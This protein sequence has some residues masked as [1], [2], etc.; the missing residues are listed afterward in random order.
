[1][2]KARWEHYSHPADVGIRGFGPTKEQ[3]FAQAGLA[4]TAV[5]TDLKTV[6]PKQP[7]K[8][9]CREQDDELLFVDWLNALIYEMA[10]RRM[11]FSK[12][13]V[14]IKDKELRAKAWGEKIDL[15]KHNPV[16]EVKAATY[17]DLKV[18]Q[19]KDGSWLAQCIVDV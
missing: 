12:F 6:E 1:M 14:G 13:E 2:S 8:I 9:T 7:V 17:A 19:S 4:L 18:L 15:K 11:L 10:T 5:I 16:V 3:A